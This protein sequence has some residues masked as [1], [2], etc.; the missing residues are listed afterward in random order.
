MV[1]SEFIISPFKLAAA[2]AILGVMGQNIGAV[3]RR[4][5][6]GQGEKAISLPTL[7]V[8]RYNAGW[9]RVPEQT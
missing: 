2:S 6:Q 5:S 9:W 7:G 4:G 3:I 1:Y 8:L